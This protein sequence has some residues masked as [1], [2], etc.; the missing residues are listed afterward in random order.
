VGQKPLKRDTIRNPLRLCVRSPL[1]PLLSLLLSPRRHPISDLRVRILESAI[2]DPQSVAPLREVSALPRFS[3]QDAKTSRQPRRWWGSRSRYALRSSPPGAD[4]EDRHTFGRGQPQRGADECFRSG[5]A[6]RFTPVRCSY[7]LKRR[8]CRLE[9]P[10]PRAAAVS[11]CF[12][13]RLLNGTAS[14][15]I[16]QRTRSSH[17]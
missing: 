15:Y 7:F 3:R 10:R 4:R 16:P 8:T 6:A 13:A 1:S 9:S 2:T 11:N 14:S 5:P 12:H 17:L